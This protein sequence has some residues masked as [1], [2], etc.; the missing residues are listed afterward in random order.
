MVVA[1]QVLDRR[2][3]AHAV[4]DRQTWDVG[5]LGTDATDRQWGIATNQPHESFETAETGQQRGQND[6]PV[7]ALGT[8]QIEDRV[9]RCTPAVGFVESAPKDHEQVQIQGGGLTG[10]G[11]LDLRAVPTC[12]EVHVINQ[13]R[14]GLAAALTVAGG[15]I[16]DELVH[17]RRRRCAWL[18]ARC[19]SRTTAETLNS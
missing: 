1:Y 8:N 14:N 16:Q 18:G 3:H 19:L 12:E 6:H 7:G 10:K 2:T 11:V 4:V 17:D 13:N 9:M 15:G 5:D